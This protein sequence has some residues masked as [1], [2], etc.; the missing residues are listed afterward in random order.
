MSLTI[1]KVLVITQ[2]RVEARCP[3]TLQVM[4]GKEISPLLAILWQTLC[5]EVAQPATETKLGRGGHVIA[6]SL[7]RKLS[8]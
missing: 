5:Q 2:T 7:G 8:R 6:F 4:L 1:H 3:T